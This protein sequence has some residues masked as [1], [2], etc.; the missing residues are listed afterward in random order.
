MNIKIKVLITGGNGFLG[1]SIVRKLLCEGHSV[2]VIS[3]NKNN[4]ENILPQ[5]KFQQS[6]N[7][8]LCNYEKDIISFN[9]EIVIHC[10]WSGGNNYNDVNNI[11]QLYDNIEPS[12]KFLE[13]LNKL[14][15]RP[16]FIGFGSFAEYGYYNEP[17]SEMF[18]EN[19]INLY[20]LSK[21]TFKKYSELLCKNYNIGWTWI[22]PCYIYGPNDVKTRLIP[23]LINKFLNN[24]DV[25]LDSCEA[26]TD[27][28]Y[29]DDF[30]KHMYQLII[31]KSTGVYNLCSGNQYLIK[32]VVNL[33]HTEI[34]NNNNVIYDPS[35][36]R[37]SIPSYICGNNKKIQ[38]TTNIIN[39]TSLIEGI[40]KT[41]NFYKK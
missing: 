25:I 36:N 32:D 4:I 31:L 6:D 13:I 20:G 12:V 33:I 22:R 29:I 10:G 16:N 5:I 35:K 8:H 34:N 17:I 23:T 41:I 28:L 1:S 24:E 11:K 18:I 15:H 14:P 2:Y 9:P 21:L 19:P 39:E 38:N 37:K 7:E 3:N 27:Y 26:I 30:V 40:Q